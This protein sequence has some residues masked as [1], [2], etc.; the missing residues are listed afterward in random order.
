VRPRV[1]VRFASGVDVLVDAGLLGDGG[2]NDE[3][4]W[5][6]TSSRVAGAVSITSRTRAGDRLE[7]AGAVGFWWQI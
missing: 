3:V 7:A 6:T 2:E 4:R 1:P 5:T